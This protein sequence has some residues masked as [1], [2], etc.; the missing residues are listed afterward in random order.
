M[1][2]GFTLA[3]LLVTLGIVGVIAAITLPSLFNNATD[4][5]IGPSLAKAVSVFD[6]ANK[7]L[8]EENEVEAVTDIIEGIDT[9]EGID[10][11][12]MKLS[13]Y[14]IFKGG[15][16]SEKYSEEGFSYF[17]DFNSG[18]M[19][20]AD[21]NPHLQ[22]INESVVIDINGKNPPNELGVDQFYFK[23]MNDGSLQPWGA[24]GEWKE[25]CPIDAIPTAL[26]YC[27]GHIF[28]NGLK[29]LYK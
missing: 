3:E 24:G 29:V 20:T 17:I 28:E 27:A 11:Y 19:V 9:K 4:A 16:S 6:Q 26:E 12:W 23:L 1:K 22:V 5:K 25:N 18:I 15:E 10:E 21:A 13:D 14:M 2:K 7:A 8:L